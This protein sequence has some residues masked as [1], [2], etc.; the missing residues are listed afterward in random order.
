MKLKKVIVLYRFVFFSN[1][2]TKFN[3][4]YFLPSSLFFSLLFVAVLVHFFS[5]PY[6]VYTSNFAKYSVLHTIISF[7]N[8]ISHLS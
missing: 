1:Y 6:R 2:L 3:L 4:I 7:Q 8:L 5:N